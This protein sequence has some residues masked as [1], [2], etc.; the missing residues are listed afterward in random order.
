M[1]KTLSLFSA[2]LLYALTMLL[3]ITAGSYIQSKTLTWGLI[4]TEA[5]MIA[6]PTLL[7]LR[8]GRVSFK[9]GLRLS[10]ISPVTG[11]LCVVLGMGMYLFALIIE[12]IMA[13]LTGMQSV[14][15][16]ND[17]LPKTGLE[18]AVYAIGMALFAPV[19]EEM[20]FRGAIQGAYEAR[21]KAGFAI[22]ITALMFAFYHFRLSGLPGLLPIAFVLGYVAWRTRS[23]Y[24]TMLVHLGN[25]GLSAVQGIVYFK[26]GHALPFISLWSALAG[27]LVAIIILLV[28]KRRYPSPSNADL[29]EGARPAPVEERSW[30]A[31]Y[32]PLVVGGALYVGVAAITL[33]ATLTLK[34]LP[35]DK[36]VYGMPSL[37]APAETRYEITNQGG[38]P[39]GEMICTLSPQDSSVRLDCERTIRAYEYQKGNSFYKDGD[40]QDTLSAEWDGKTMSLVSFVYERNGEEGSRFT[41]SVKDGQVVTDDASSADSSGSESAALDKTGLVEFEWAWHAALLKA[42]SGQA[43]SVPFARLMMWDDSKKKS[44]PVVKTEILTVHDDETLALAAGDVSVRKLTLGN[45]AAW[46]AREDA[47]AG[48]PRPVKF[49]DGVLIYTAVR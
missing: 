6:L 43:Y 40:H 39:V 45:Q 27:L 30:F 34:Y 12:G 16:Q 14:P 49:D 19:C 25:N 10:P 13:Q 48:L 9:T 29:V 32:S 17:L 4:A 5:L 15:I 23:I 21:K 31:T 7:F 1:K 47:R 41:S 37:S 11:I 22:T 44:V 3:V 24:A 33:A 2:N 8:Q 18:V 26:T 20:L 28:I 42:N 38:Q 35:A 36:L 46:Y